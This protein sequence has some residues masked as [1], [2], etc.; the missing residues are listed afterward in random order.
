MLVCAGSAC[1]DGVLCCVLLLK[2]CEREKSVKEEKKEKRIAFIEGVFKPRK[3][4]LENMHIKFRH[5]YYCFSNRLMI[6][7]K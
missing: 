7:F 4:M 2:Y 5:E 6:D 3:F 1:H